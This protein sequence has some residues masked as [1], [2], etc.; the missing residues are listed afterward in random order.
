MADP[1]DIAEM[2]D[3]IRKVM[4]STMELHAAVEESRRWHRWEYVTAPYVFL[5]GC[6]VAPYV[7]VG[8]SVWA[9]K[10]LLGNCSL[11]TSHR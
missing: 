11:V 9:G 1:L 4:R 8:A 5:I 10:L 7:F 6:L 3:A 2:E